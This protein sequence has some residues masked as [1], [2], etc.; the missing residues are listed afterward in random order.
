[1]IRCMK[2]EDGYYDDVIVVK[3]GRYIKRYSEEAFLQ[4]VCK[5]HTTAYDVRLVKECWFDQEGSDEKAYEAFS[6]LFNTVS[7]TNK[8]KALEAFEALWNE[9]VLL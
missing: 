5:P 2:L 6:F 7:V 9:I 3:A 1:M 8:E 4:M